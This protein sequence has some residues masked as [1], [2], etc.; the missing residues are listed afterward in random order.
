MSTFSLIITYSLRILRREWRKFV[1][2]FLSLFVAGVVLSLM[3]F[4]TES[5][6]L[7][8]NEKSRELTGGDINIG[9]NRSH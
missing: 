7:L 3:L 4:L 9:D 6:T 8:L 1:L 5:G 2:P